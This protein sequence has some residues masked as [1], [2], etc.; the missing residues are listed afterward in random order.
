MTEQNQPLFL[1]T[2]E[3]AS[4]LRVKERK[5]YDL[6]SSELIPYTRTIG[7][8]LFPREDILSWIEAGSHATSNNLPDVIT[9]S[10][11]PLLDWAIRE[12]GCGL[13]TLFNGSIEGIARFSTG[14]AAAAAMHIPE[15]D[16]WNIQAVSTLGLRNCVLIA[17][18]GRSRGLI[19]SAEARPAVTCFSDLRGRRLIRR[20][21]GAG[22][23][24]IFE[25]LA[26]DAGLSDADF[27]SADGVA[28]TEHDAA[29]AVASGVA[30]AAIGI[31][32][33][34]RQFKLAFLPL[35]EERFDLLV[36]RRVYFTAPMQ[37]LLTFS[38]SE[39][40]GRMAETMGGYDLTESGTVRWLSP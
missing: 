31:A 24:A 25:R 23:T 36:E 6:V 33:M 38:R 1:T 11:D 7:K 40:F 20:Q 15:E 21:S 19:L 35:L 39:P 13:A 30:D 26:A 2:K 8:L 5:V 12:S 4:L 37:A 32:A 3:V 34:A 9:G 14:E 27:P 29:A 18:V 28:H 17:W 22:A 10:H 16:G